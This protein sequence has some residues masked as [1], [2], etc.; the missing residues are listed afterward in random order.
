MLQVATLDLLKFEPFPALAAAV[1]ACAE[2]VLSRWQKLV[3]E[4]LPTADELTLSQLRDELPEVLNELA[5]TMAAVDGSHFDKL[6]SVAQGHGQVRFHQSYNIGELLVEYGLLRSILIDEVM[7]QLGRGL[8]VAESAAMHMGIDTA[9]RNGVTKFTAFQQQ[10]MKAVVDA[11]SKNLSFLSHDLRGGLNG[12]LLMVEVLKRELAGEP[13]FSESIH[14]LDSMRQS[15]LDT[16]GTMDRFLHAE[17]FRQGKVQP[18]NTTIPI[19]QMLNDLLLGFRRLADAK[20]IKL[21]IEADAGLTAHADR[22]LLQLILQNFL[23]NAIK[24]TSKGTV[25][26]KAVQLTD[27]KLRISIIDTGPGISA[28]RMDNLFA[29]YIRGE[30]HGQEGV[31]LGLSIAKQAADLIGATIKVE[32]K[33]GT[34]SAFNLDLP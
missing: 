7:M 2:T 17:R 23:S 32:S 26:I 1:D 16:V 22:E 15:I 9:I 8:T 34:G 20:G 10:Q 28:E 31:G 11:Q 6:A 19:S 25:E 21:S 29:P 5:R 18:H 30:T 13:K 33:V 4:K 12:V 27:G 14:D 3:C 24:Y